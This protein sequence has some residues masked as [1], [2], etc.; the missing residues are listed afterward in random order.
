MKVQILFKQS[1]AQLGI[2]DFVNTASISILLNKY[3]IF[4]LF[5]L[6]LNSS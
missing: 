3:L 6:F 5:F 1:Y 2:S 4:S